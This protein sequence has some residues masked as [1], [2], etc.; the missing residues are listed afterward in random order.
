MQSTFS[1]LILFFALSFFIFISTVKGQITD[2]S[3][4]YVVVSVF[5]KDSDA[6]QYVESSDLDV[7][8][9]KHSYP[10]KRTL[11]YCYTYVSKDLEA[12]LSES[13]KLRAKSGY[14]ET[15]VFVVLH[16]DEEPVVASERKEPQQETPAE[17]EP[18][19][20]AKLE[21]AEEEI[22]GIESG[23][24]TVM[25]DEP[26]VEEIADTEEIKYYKVLTNTSDVNNLKAVPSTIKV[27]DGERSTL[28]AILKANELD[29]V[30]ERSSGNHK[31]QIVSE[32]PGYK[33]VSYD[34]DLDN[35]VNDVTTNYARL[36]DGVIELDLALQPLKT[37]DYQILYNIYFF[38]DASVMKP[39]SRFE[40][41]SLY[42]L[43]EEK[44]SMKIRIH[45]HTNGK[46]FGKI[47]KLE[48]DDENWF[49]LTPNNKSSTG[50]ATELSKQ[51]SITLK[52]YLVSKGIDESRLEIKGW[53]GKKMLHDEEH[54]L[55]HQNVR[56]EIEV[57]EE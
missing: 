26:E 10:G 49:K 14:E 23:A 24:D 39:S 28:V 31:V 42:K 12:S 21:D 34:I 16:E 11:Y 46:A 1:K 9:L 38:N 6:Q 40:L 27:I 54:P 20:E 45:G 4:K 5:L 3:H 35:P 19:A 53:G 13:E 55:A 51:R 56:V 36:N 32:A 52:R 57:I 48:E 33:R 50:S 43:L 8:Y 7:K 18:E 17:P 44:P 15:W 2:R 25:P 41:E 37:G 29:S 47:I 22:T 30:K